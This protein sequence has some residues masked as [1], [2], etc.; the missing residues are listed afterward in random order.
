MIDEIS[1]AEFDSLTSYRIDHHV[2]FN[3]KKENPCSSM[4]T[5]V[6]VM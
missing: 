4:Y 1:M 2:R 5:H 6:H 3:T